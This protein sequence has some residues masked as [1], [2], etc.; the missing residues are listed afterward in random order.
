MNADDWKKIQEREK[1]LAKLRQALVEKLQVEGPPE[2]LDPDVAL[3]GSGYG[4]DS[5]DAVELV[6][7]L[8]TE[9][10]LQVSDSDLFDMR[11]S[12]RTL[13]TLADLVMTLKKEPTHV[14]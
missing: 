8:E 14:A 11:G 1:I 4:L 9:F 10:G 5:L 12:T 13:N 6:I 2:E 3:F 7:F